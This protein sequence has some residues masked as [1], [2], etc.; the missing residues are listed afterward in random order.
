MLARKQEISILQCNIG[1]KTVVAQPVSKATINNIS[2]NIQHI[3]Q[4]AISAEELSKLPAFEEFLRFQAFMDLLKH[5]DSQKINNIQQKSENKRTFDQMSGSHHYP[6]R[7][8]TAD[9]RVICKNCE[10]VGHYT[11]QCNQPSCQQ[12][13]RVQNQPGIKKQ[14][15]DFNWIRP[16]NGP[17]SR[18]DRKKP[19]DTVNNSH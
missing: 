5:Q 17:N 9:G 19:M 6:A 2:E 3:P 15:S 12:R 4:P 7:W 10:K 11:C 13:D 1:T 8:R 16:T 14:R 18:V